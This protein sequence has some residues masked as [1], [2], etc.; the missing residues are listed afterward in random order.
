MEPSDENLTCFRLSSHSLEI[1]DLIIYLEKTVCVT[2]SCI[3]W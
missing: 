3:G 1:G 2:V